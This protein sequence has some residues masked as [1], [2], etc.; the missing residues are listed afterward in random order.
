[1]RKMRDFEIV[2]KKKKNAIIAEWDTHWRRERGT[3]SKKIEEKKKL[4]SHEEGVLE[5]KIL[6]CE[7]GNYREAACV[8]AELSTGK[9]SNYG[10]NWS[11]R[12]GWKCT[13]GMLNERI[14]VGGVQPY[15]GRW[16]R[17]QK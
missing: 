3:S 12:K 4:D 11:A 2:K 6:Q 15:T 14:R 1:M 13:Y 10:D 8:M 17:L 5:I 9:N 7:W 16:T